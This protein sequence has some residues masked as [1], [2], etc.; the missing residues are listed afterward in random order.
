MTVEVLCFESCPNDDDGDS[1][2]A[3]VRAGA[4]ISA[5]PAAI[6]LEAVQRAGCSATVISR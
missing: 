5:V 3:W 1:G 4:V 2:G 6:L